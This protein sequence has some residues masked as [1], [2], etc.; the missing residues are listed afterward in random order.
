MAAAAAFEQQQKFA[1]AVQAYQRALQLMPR[2]A[3][4]AEGLKRADFGRHMAEGQKALAG[5]RFPDAVREFEAALKVMPN[6]PAATKGLQQA[7]Q[8][9]P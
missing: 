9:K 8:G 3:K 6:Q 4:A 1:E 7:R 2:D 5:K